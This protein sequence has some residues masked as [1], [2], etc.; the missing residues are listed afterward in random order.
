MCWVCFST[1]PGVTT[2]IRAI[3]VFE[4]PS[5]MRPS[6]S[7]SR[8]RQAAHGVVGAAS[9]EQLR[10]HLRV[11]HGAAADDVLEGLEERVDVGHPVLEQVAHAAGAV[12]E[13]L[14]G[15]GHLDVLGQHEHR[16]PGHLPAGL[17]GRP[18]PLVGV[19]RRHPDVDHGD[20]RA[21]LAH[22]PDE[23]GTVGHRGHDL[24]AGLLEEPDQALAEQDRV[25]GQD[26]PHGRSAVSRVGPPRGLS[27]SNRPSTACSR[28]ASPARP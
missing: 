2:R 22:R 15:V 5:A 27:T 26:Y 3:A 10:D 16:R 28:S 8:G 24:G 25:L 23:R 18:Q 1:A 7:R 20:V 17:D 6:T 11:E 21:V 9:G 14:V 12:G 13:Q 4:C 19:R